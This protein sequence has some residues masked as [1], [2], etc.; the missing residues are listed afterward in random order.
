MRKK[1]T[2]Q[3]LAILL[4]TTVMIT[5][6]SVSASTETTNLSDVKS[7]IVEADIQT[8]TADTTSTK[9]ALTVNTSIVTECGDTITTKLN[10]NTT[11]EQKIGYADVDA[12]LNNKEGVLK[13]LED[14]SEDVA[15]IAQFDE[16][17]N[18][19]EATKIDTANSSITTS[20]NKLTDASNEA[21]KTEEDMKKTTVAAD[22]ATKAADVNDHDATKAAVNEAK[23]AFDQAATDKNTAEIAL[24]EC[25]NALDTANENLISAKNAYA[26]MLEDKNNAAADL[27]T[28][29]ENVTKAQE[30]VNSLKSEIDTLKQNYEQ[31]K[32]ALLLA[33]YNNMKALAKDENN[34][35]SPYSKDDTSLTGTETA[36]DEYWNAAKAYFLLYLKYV[37]GDDNVGEVTDNQTIFYNNVEKIPTGGELRSA[38]VTINGEDMFFNFHIKDETGDIDIYKKSSEH[39]DAVEGVESQEEERAF[40]NNDTTYEEKADDIVINGKDSNNNDTKTVADKTTKVNNSNNL[41]LG[42]NQKVLDTK[43]TNHSFEEKNIT[44]ETGRTTVVN[45]D[46]GNNG[47]VKY[48]KDGLIDFSNFSDKVKNDVNAY[49]NENPDINSVNVTYSYDVLFIGTITETI[50]VNKQSSWDSFWKNVGSFLNIG[51]YTITYQKDNVTT[52]EVDQIVETITNEVSIET[53]NSGSSSKEFF[54]S[55]NSRDNNAKKAKESK[56]Q[57][58]KKKYTDVSVT[59]NSG[60]SIAGNYYYLSWSYKEN[61]KTTQTIVNTYDATKYTDTVIKEKI[62]HVDPVAEQN[63]WKEALD[64]TNDESVKKALSDITAKLDEINKK[65]ELANDAK[66]AVGT[67]KEAVEK[68]KNALDKLSVGDKGYGKAKEAYDTAKINF[69]NAKEFMT[70]AENNVNFAEKEYQ[71]AVAQLSRLY[72]IPSGNN[73]PSGNSDNNDSSS[74]PTTVSDTPVTNNNQTTI[75][76]TVARRTENTNN[77]A[78]VINAENNGNESNTNT[79][80]NNIVAKDDNKETVTLGENEVPLAA[81]ITQDADTPFPW[82]IIA[83]IIAVLLI[84]GYIVYKKQSEK[85][86]QVS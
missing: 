68:A 12:L 66:T 51:N 36:S 14:A 21:G 64:S 57:E 29:E 9:E 84:T 59:I 26:K 67:A 30:Y 76:T 5:P 65:Q 17:V 1:G 48:K 40:K 31:S 27:Q 74:T 42:S 41:S 3:F 75:T 10:T 45:T 56:E 71:R 61:S 85:N 50:N 73:E 63:L 52:E 32:E 79:A 69:E 47:V 58:L 54:I 77:T 28:A 2:K 11:E 53:S 43:E 13:N 34:T 35:V 23:A 83:L 60:S 39:T 25:S 49:I 7:A 6:I 33:A 22:D 70:T 82:W 20:N 81:N 8:K 72:D 16:D 15:K 78:I 62:E 37:Y 44:R 86:K 55:K 24:N 46:K 4:A 18:K 38:K 80:G 19:K